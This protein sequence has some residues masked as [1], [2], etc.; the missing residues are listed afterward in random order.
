MTNELT[1]DANLIELID[2]RAAC[3]GWPKPETRSEYMAWFLDEIEIQKDMLEDS[4]DDEERARK[5]FIQD[6]QRAIDQLR[7]QGITPIRLP[8]QGE[9]R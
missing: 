4:E 6:L 1:I 3:G 9:V 7:E 2:D 8:W 5:A